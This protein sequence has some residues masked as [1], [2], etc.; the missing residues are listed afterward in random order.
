MYNN[1]FIC[2]N[3]PPT[4]LLWFLVLLPPSWDSQFPI[5]GNQLVILG[6]LDL[7]N[8]I[9]HFFTCIFDYIHILFLDWA[10][11]VCYFVV[12]ALIFNPC[13]IPTHSFGT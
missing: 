5:S 13:C 10:I 3:G 2:L 6:E 1:Y 12:V 11:P 7:V 8:I 4:C 9:R